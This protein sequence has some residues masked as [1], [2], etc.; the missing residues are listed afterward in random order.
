M[1]TM[2]VFIFAMKSTF[3]PYICCKR[4]SIIPIWHWTILYLVAILILCHHH[5]HHGHHDQSHHSNHH[6]LME[7]NWFGMSAFARVKSLK[8][9]LF[10]SNEL[11]FSLVFDMHR[12]NANANANASLIINIYIVHRLMCINISRVSK[13]SSMNATTTTNEIICISSQSIGWEKKVKNLTHTKLHRKKNV[14]SR[15]F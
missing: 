7:C 3:F 5:H 9:S 14:N 1:M 10:H 11:I 12:W 2:I 15:L 13:F 6:S 4:H 8:S